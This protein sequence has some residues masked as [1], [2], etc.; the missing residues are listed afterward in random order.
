MKEIE[1]KFAMQLKYEQDSAKFYDYIISHTK[2]K[3][4]VDVVSKI[5][6]DEI[7]HIKLVQE[8]Q[9]LVK[10]RDIKAVGEIIDVDIDLKGFREDY[11][12][13]L[14]NTKIDDYSHAI[15]DLIQKI[16][17][18]CVYVSFNKIPKY[19]KKLL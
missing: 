14:I 12:S 7:R 6:D 15:I 1:D 5:K 13:V 10:G 19:T 9:K 3:D 18:K 11:N 4:I 16:D 8:M 17:G 2:E